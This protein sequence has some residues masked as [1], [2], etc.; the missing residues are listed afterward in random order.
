M[1]E[2]ERKREISGES[3][4]EREREKERE[5]VWERE[6]ERERERE[7][8]R[9]PFYTSCFRCHIQLTMQLFSDA[10]AMFGVHSLPIC[11]AW[12]FLSWYWPVMLNIENTISQRF[13]PPQ[14]NS[15]RVFT[16]GLCSKNSL[17]MNYKH[18][19]VRL[20]VTIVIFV[21][22]FGGK[23]LFHKLTKQYWK[24]T[25]IEWFS[26]HPYFRSCFVKTDHTQERRLMMRPIVLFK[27]TNLLQY[28][29]SLLNSKIREAFQIVRYFL[30]SIWLVN[31]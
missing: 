1:R 8:K 29:R 24:R 7:K 13:H 12:D 4:W 3:V 16:L 22:D 19:K 5:S 6:G 26:P 9:L 15:T 2:S 28:L 11:H 31:K 27:S 30:Q 25:L 14:D 18:L 17:T 10:L 20:T 21:A 23:E